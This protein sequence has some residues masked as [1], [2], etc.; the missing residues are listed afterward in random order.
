MTLRDSQRRSVNQKGYARNQRWHPLGKV[1]RPPREMR[2]WLL[3][4]GS[5]TRRLHQYFG[6]IQVRVMQQQTGR[7][8]FD[9]GAACSPPATI[10]NVVL[11]GLNQ[12][13]LVVAHSVSPLCPRSA[14]ALM[15]KKLG[16]Q[17]L[18][19]VL[20]SRPGFVRYQREW[21]LLDPRHP[22][23]KLAQHAKG[24]DLSRSLWARRA[25]FCPLRKQGHSVQVTEIFCIDS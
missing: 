25:I 14:L 8:I 9:E 18:G 16:K 24:T 6:A 4:R 10:R 1:L 20:F 21:A 3:E 11:S 22:L 12:H 19:S 15:L 23:Y 17:A 7:L 13:P 2:E 5:L